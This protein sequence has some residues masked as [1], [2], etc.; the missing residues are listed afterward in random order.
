MM[1]TIMMIILGSIS[2]TPSLA[3]TPPYNGI[4]YNQKLAW[5]QE[6]LWNLGKNLTIG[7]SYTYRI[8]DPDAILNYSAEVYHYFTKNL[9]HNGSLCYVI[10]MDFVTLVSTDENQIDGNIW[11]VQ[12][13]ISDDFSN[14]VRNSVFHVD[15]ESFE[16]RSADTI[17]PDTIRYADSLQDT[18][19]SI[20]KYTA[21]QS[22]LLQPGVTWGEVTEYHDR[23]QNPQMKVL[24]EMKSN[25]TPYHFEILTQKIISEQ[26]GI[27]VF[28]VGY[29][30]DIADAS[31]LI[32]DDKKI[33]NE[34][35]TNNITNHYLV[36]SHLPFPVSGLHYNPSYVIEPHK[37]YEFELITYLETKSN[38]P[39]Q[40]PIDNVVIVDVDPDLPITERGTIE[41]TFPDDVIPDDDVTIDDPVLDDNTVDNNYDDEGPDV[42]IIP[43]DDTITNDDS[44]QD[45]VIT[46]NNSQPSQNDS[47]IPVI[48]ILAIVLGAAGIVIWKKPSFQWKKKN[49]NITRKK[50][51]FTDKI[52][53]EIDTVEP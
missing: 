16:V 17:H 10:Q 38:R 53:L 52:N 34:E 49:Q 31:D 13:T 50:I 41:L 2:A 12:A 28:S 18:I 20:H 32:T 37:E 30:I 11:I 47:T 24:D 7:D 42:I 46:S 19:F 26:K 36:S 15:A 23:G 44:I 29:E 21:T 5:Q 8:C 25:V 27:D 45:D 6:H 35:D 9:E 39:P 22:K 1:I 3:T 33:K 14:E 51:I 48:V 43:D 4:D 40:E